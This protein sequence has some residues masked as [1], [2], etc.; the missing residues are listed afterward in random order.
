[1]G[2]GILNTNP[3]V[4][5]YRS[6]S[7]VKPFP[8]I[9]DSVANLS[10]QFLVLPTCLF[11]ARNRTDVRIILLEYYCNN[12]ATVHRLAD[13]WHQESSDGG[14]TFPARGLK[15]GFPST[16]NAKI[17]RKNSFSPSDGGTIAPVKPLFWVAQLGG[18]RNV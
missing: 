7:F 17:L 8:S 3:F 12:L 11:K 4:V 6:D 9:Y 2:L 18:V 15:Y 5:Y 13:G 10:L 1:M 16:I 14:L